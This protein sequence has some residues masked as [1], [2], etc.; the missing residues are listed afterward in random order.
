MTKIDP[1]ALTTTA[2]VTPAQALRPSKGQALRASAHPGCFAC[3]PTRDHGLGLEFHDV[4]DGRV[5][6]TFACPAS[7]EG[8]PGLLHGGIIAT[9]LDAAMTNC[10]FA[11]GHQAVT[12]ELSIKYRAPV[13]LS[14]IA[15][16]EAIAS[17]DLFPLF[18]MEA[19]LSQQGETKA[20]ATAKFIVT[21]GL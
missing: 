15:V 20:T 18:V 6:A 17:R 11:L 10:L 7:F 8:Y 1:L 13:Q 12:A 19:G 21:R 16:V 2:T 9:I 14:R 4:G 5:R 3:S